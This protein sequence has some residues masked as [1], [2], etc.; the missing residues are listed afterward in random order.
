[1]FPLGD[2]FEPA[3]QK[4][5]LARE[6]PMSPHDLLPP[7]SPGFLRRLERLEQASPQF[8]GLVLEGQFLEFLKFLE[9]S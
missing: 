3:S 5:H 9:H 2:L 1:M 7:S 4:M 8:M 6:A